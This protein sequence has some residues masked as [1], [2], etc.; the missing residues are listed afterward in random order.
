MGLVI[1]PA[2]PGEAPLVLQLV[3]ELAEYERLLHAVEATG[4]VLDL[5]LFGPEPRIFCDIVEWSGEP[6]G[7]AL[8]YYTFSTFQGRHGIYLEDLFVRPDHRGQGLGKA[9]LERLA[10]RCRDGELGRLEWSVLDWNEPSIG[11]YRALGAEP[12]SGWTRYRLAGEP[13]SQLASEP[14]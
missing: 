3:R 14:S 1:R 7:F 8:W 6:A 13:L 2:R 9:L 5:A 12:V 4:A 10:A 11:F